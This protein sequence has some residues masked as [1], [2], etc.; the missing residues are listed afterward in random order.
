MWTFKS[1]HNFSVKEARSCNHTKMANKPGRT[2]LPHLSLSSHT[3]SPSSAVSPSF[4]F[5]R[6]LVNFRD[7]K[8]SLQNKAT[9]LFPDIK[10]S[11]SPFK[12]RDD[13]LLKERER[14]ALLRNRSVELTRGIDQKQ[15]SLSS[16]PLFLF[17]FT[18]PHH[19]EL[20]N[21]NFKLTEGASEKETE[22]ETDE[23]TDVL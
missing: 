19:Q 11:K 2:S 10:G 20:C 17:I 22:R 23:E 16:P 9:L 13:R 18:S 7:M 12:P 4:T 1:Y 21:V 5:F 14:W 6:H 15:G 3:I 8:G